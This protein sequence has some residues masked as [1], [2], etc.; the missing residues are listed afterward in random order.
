MRRAT[1]VTA[2]AALLGAGMIQ[3]AAPARVAAST[4]TWT[5]SATSGPST[6]GAGAAMAY[7]AATSSDVT[8]GSAK[9]AQLAKIAPAKKYGRRP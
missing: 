8:F 4:S 1:V 5:N 6:G 7:D 2:A 3:V 9:S